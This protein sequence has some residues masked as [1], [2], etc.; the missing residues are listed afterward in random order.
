VVAANVPAELDPAV[1]TLRAAIDATAQGTPIAVDD[2]TT[3]EA[4]AAIDRWAHENCGFAALDVTG[5]GGDMT[6]IPATLAAGP[7]ALSFDNGGDPT[8]GGFVL[9]LARVRDGATYSLDG[10]RD[11]SVD[12]AAAADVVAAVQP[13]PGS[14]IGYGTAELTAGKYLV[15]S[16]IGTPPAFTG[17]AAAEIEVS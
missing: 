15:V 14:P 9:L 3:T 2:A 5:T 16:P 13:G 10:I 8:S 4:S 6:G 17:T 12:F 7:V 11:G 1:A